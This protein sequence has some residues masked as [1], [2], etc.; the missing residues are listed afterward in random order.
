LHRIACGDLQMRQD[1]YASAAMEYSRAAELSAT[2]DEISARKQKEVNQ[3]YK[4]AAEAW[5]AAG[6]RGKA[7]ECYTKAAL[8]MMID[9]DDRETVDK[10][11]HTA[12]E[13]AIQFH[14]PD[15]LNR[16]SLHRMTQNVDHSTFGHE[17]DNKQ[18]RSS[19][20]EQLKAIARE[21]IARSAY[22]H[23]SVQKIVRVFVEMGNYRSALYAAGAVT[24]LLEE[25][26]YATVSLFKAYLTETILQLVS[27]SNNSLQ[28]F[29]FYLSCVLI[30]FPLLAFFCNY[31]CP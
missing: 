29:P 30:L 31:F 24:T 2:S 8:G 13:D 17:E 1:S 3:L 27:A 28:N 11:T 14:V 6:E 4:N 22:S 26:G 7:A 15:I 25:T 10:P 9:K 23:E 5:I 20:L 16:M 21:D 12:L 19:T 18:Q